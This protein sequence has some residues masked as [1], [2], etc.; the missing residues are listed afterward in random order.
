MLYLLWELPFPQLPVVEGKAYLK[1]TKK[2]DIRSAQIGSLL[3]LGI[4]KVIKFPVEFLKF[5]GYRR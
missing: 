4:M 2:V 5:L 1:M 3:S